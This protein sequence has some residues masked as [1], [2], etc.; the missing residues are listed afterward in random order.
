M[1]REQYQN[2]IKELLQAVQTLLDVNKTM[3]ERV[4]L[5]E[6]KAAAYDDLKAKYDKLEGELAMR[7]RAQHGK[8]GEKP[9]DKSSS[10]DENI[11]DDDENDYI[12]NGSKRDA[13]PAEE[14]AIY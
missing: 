5:L 1:E 9:K 12:E 4:D 2:Q 8:G 13:F 3:E 14:P 7:K 6:K 11:K 10:S